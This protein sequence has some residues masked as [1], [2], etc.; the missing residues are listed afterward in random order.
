MYEF[1][2]CFGA[3]P[4]KHVFR[5]IY[6]AGGILQG[7]WRRERA[8]PSRPPH[9]PGM[10]F[11]TGQ[12]WGPAQTPSAAPFHFFYGSRNATIRVCISPQIYHF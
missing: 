4:Q 6:V 10:I 7:G 1:F 3:M 2:C 12:H 5:S 8:D 9:S 11:P